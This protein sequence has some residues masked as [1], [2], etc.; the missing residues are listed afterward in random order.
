MALIVDVAT[1]MREGRPPGGPVAE[2]AG[3]VF[4]QLGSNQARAGRSLAGLLTA[5]QAGARAAWRHMAGTAVAAGAPAPD[6][7]L[8]AEAVFWLVDSLSAA[9]TRGYTEEQSHTAAQ[10][11][12]AY[13][14]LAE[15]L[16]SGRADR[17]AIDAAAGR[18]RW[19]I[20]AA[21]AVVLLDDDGPAGDL[22]AGSDQRGVQSLSFRRRTL[23]GLLVAAAQGSAGRADLNRAFRGTGAVVGPAVHPAALPGTL[24]L[25]E[26]ALRLRRS[27]VLTGDPVFAADHLDAVIVHRDPHSL[28]EL[29]REVLAPLD[30]LPADAR[31][32]MEQ[33][34]LSWLQQLGDRAAMAAE[35]HLH[36]QTVRYRLGQLRNLFGSD[37]DDPSVR[38]KLMLALCWRSS[39]DG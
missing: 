36:P 7:A 26:V 15:L 33:T 30:G 13:A 2:L 1:E 6:V 23:R 39:V 25:V 37:L 32:R 14:E 34:L 22:L 35:L 16:L 31:Q 29:R 24:E 19:P 4:E 5:Y 21:I 9:S 28:A 10:R 12:R 3:P 38:R 11:E 18:A 17:A 8:L 20:P 27:G